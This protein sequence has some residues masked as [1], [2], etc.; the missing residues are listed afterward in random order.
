MKIFVIAKM[1]T[2]GNKSQGLWSRIHEKFHWLV[3]IFCGLSSFY[4]LYKSCYKKKHEK[5]HGLSLDI[6]NN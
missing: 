3:G 4:T 1:E 2:G 5:F 6:E